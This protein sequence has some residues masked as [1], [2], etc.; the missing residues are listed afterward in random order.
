YII[1][2]DPTE[3][4]LVVA[5]MKAKLTKDLLLQQFEIVNEF[6][7]DSAR[8]MMSIIVK[9]KSG[10]RFV[11][12]KGAP[13]VLLNNCETILWDNKQ[14]RLSSEYENKVR[15]AIESLASDALRTIAVAFKPL[16]PNQQVIN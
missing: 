15:N 14:N 7:F 12:T 10:N 2:G 13:D 11:I 1:D 8:K 4:A 9:D 6:P 3:G 5:G 16:R